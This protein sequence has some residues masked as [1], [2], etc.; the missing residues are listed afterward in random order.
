MPWPSLPLEIIGH[1]CKGQTQRVKQ[2]TVLKEQ[3]LTVR[4]NL[5]EEPCERP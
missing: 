1:K 2:E 4:E 3:P 5:E